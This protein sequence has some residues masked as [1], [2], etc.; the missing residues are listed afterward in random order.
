MRAD[1]AVRSWAGAG[2][3]V[4][5]I[6]R[7]LCLGGADP[8]SPLL[9]CIPT[10]LWEGTRE[11]PALFMFVSFILDVTRVRS[12]GHTSVLVEGL[13]CGVRVCKHGIYGQ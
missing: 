12:K 11:L 6:T 8:P 7:G 5:R 13:V 3:V 2:S 10:L 9:A 1:G 4:P